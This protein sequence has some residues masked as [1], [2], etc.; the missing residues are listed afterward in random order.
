MP[1]E[2]LKVDLKTVSHEMNLTTG[3]GK[4]LRD[5]EKERSEGGHSDIET[6]LVSIS[7]APLLLRT[8]ALS[9]LVRD[10]SKAA[11]IAHCL[12]K[13][14]EGKAAEPKEA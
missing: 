9:P 10:H 4:V 1:L 8:N 11:T 6:V 13:K 12:V 7:N 2:K 3:Q 5:E 14:G